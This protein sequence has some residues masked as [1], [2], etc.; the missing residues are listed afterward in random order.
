MTLAYQGATAFSV[1][2]F[3]YYGLSCLFTN[4]MAAEFERFGLARL[5]LLTGTLE[6]LGALGLIAGQFIPGLVIVSA[7]GLALLM[8]MGIFTRVRVGDSL[9]QTV[10]AGILL[11]VNVFIVWHAVG[12]HQA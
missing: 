6:I 10:P 1:V 2:L 12:L 11:A 8:A 5:R 7:G 9:A 3:L 4:G